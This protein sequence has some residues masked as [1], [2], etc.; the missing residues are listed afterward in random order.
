MRWFLGTAVAVAMAIV[1]YIGSAVVSL[2]GLV[3]AARA[4]DGDTVLMRTD[5]ARLRR[6]LVDQIVSAYLKQLGRDRPV[7]PLERVA[8]NTYGASVADAMI[9]KLLTAE[10][11]T[12]ILA[13][14][15]VSSAGATVSIPRLTE[16]KT[17]NLFETLG[18][19][20]PITPVEF[21]IWLDRPAGTGVNVHFEGDGWKLSGIQLPTAVVQTLAQELV[22]AKGR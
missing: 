7:K 17:S 6:S 13:K 16:I 1:L 4:G 19:L 14:G 2:H 18:R 15:T 12:A 20:R 21:L 3:E 8:A 11:L 22:S 9:A 10:N 5:T